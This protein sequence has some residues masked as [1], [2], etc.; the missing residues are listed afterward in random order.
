MVNGCKLNPA[1]WRT[2]V[3]H[4]HIRTADLLHPNCTAALCSCWPILII[5]IY[6]TGSY[7]KSQESTGSYRIL[8]NATKCYRKEAN[9]FLQEGEWATGSCMMLQEGTGKYWDALIS[10]TP[11]KV[12]RG[13]NVLNSWAT[14][15]FW[16]NWCIQI[17]STNPSHIRACFKYAS[18][19]F[20]KKM[21]V[22]DK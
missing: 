3:A 7:K 6:V 21:K 12:K 20:G 22:Y 8:W 18:N 16:C 5:I 9:S 14:T 10:V 17:W 4:I 2:I 11:Q 19:Q 15:L 1:S 13:V